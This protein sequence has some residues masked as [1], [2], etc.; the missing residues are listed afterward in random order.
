MTTTTTTTTTTNEW[1]TTMTTT[2]FLRYYGKRKPWRSFCFNFKTVRMHKPQCLWH[3]D[4]PSVRPPIHTSVS[5]CVCVSGRVYPAHAHALTS[6]VLYGF[7]LPCPN[8]SSFRFLMIRNGRLETQR[9]K[10][11]N[12]VTGLENVYYTPSKG[13]HKSKLPSLTTYYRYF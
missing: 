1:T 6:Y 12:P 11:R 2:T 7:V 3:P 9:K 13:W 5:V 10:G 4:C 8:P